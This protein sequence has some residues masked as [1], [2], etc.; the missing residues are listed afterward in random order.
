M[1]APQEEAFDGIDFDELHETTGLEKDEIKCLKLCFNLFDVKKQDFLSADDLDDIL[2]YNGRP[3]MKSAP[4]LFV[5]FQSHG[6]PS[7][8]G[9][10]EGDPGRN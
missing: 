6:F 2:R 8:Q 7:L 1:S 10:V 4:N 9:G 5:H 3:S